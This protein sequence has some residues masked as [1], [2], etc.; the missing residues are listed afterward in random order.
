MGF[1]RVRKALKGHSGS[2]S[3]CAG[4]RLG[5]PARVAIASAGEARLNGG[6]AAACVLAA[7]A[8]VVVLTLFLRHGAGGAQAGAATNDR[9]TGNGEAQPAVASGRAEKAVTDSSGAWR[10]VAGGGSPDSIACPLPLPA[11]TGGL[12]YR[13]AAETE[14]WQAVSPLDCREYAEALL[15]GLS[16]TGMQLEGAGFLDIYGD[17]WGCA[18][19]TGDGSAFIVSLRSSSSPDG[20]SMTQISIVH[21]LAPSIEEGF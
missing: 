9:G 19:G 7:L 20:T 21:I 10:E 12:S 14:A 15:C 6:R 3:Y 4:G 13:K 5:H 8:I 11:Q 2:G 17:A 1:D 16:G 18:L